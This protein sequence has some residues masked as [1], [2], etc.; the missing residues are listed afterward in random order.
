M[1][2]YFNKEFAQIPYNSG[3]KASE[4]KAFPLLAVLL[5]RL[6][7]RKYSGKSNF[8][9]GGWMKEFVVE[10]ISN[11]NKKDDYLR[12]VFNTEELLGELSTS[13]IKTTEAFWLK[14]TT[15]IQIKLT[16]DIFK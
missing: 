13:Q 8:A 2:N 1:Q 15:P 9:L 16:I 4:F 10:E 14:Y 6:R 5:A 7:K 12:G 11:I 3:F